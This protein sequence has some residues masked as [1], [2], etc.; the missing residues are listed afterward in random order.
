MTLKVSTATKTVIGCSASSPAT[1]WILLPAATGE[2]TCMEH[3]IGLHSL[4][5]LVFAVNDH[6]LSG[7]VIVISAK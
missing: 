3:S 4:G 1:A 7:W 6:F 5:Y 2:F